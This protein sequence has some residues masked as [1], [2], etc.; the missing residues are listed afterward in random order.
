MALSNN[1]FLLL[2]NVTVWLTLV[3]PAKVMAASVVPG[4]SIEAKPFPNVQPVSTNQI[5][6]FSWGSFV[7][8][9]VV[10]LALLL[11]FAVAVKRFSRSTSGSSSWFKLLD[12]QQMGPGHNLY[13]VELAGRMQILGVTNQ[14]MVKIADLDDAELAGEILQD[15]AW[16]NEQILP[17]WWSQLL[18][19][20]KGSKFADELKRFDKGGD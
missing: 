2:I 19:N 8:I 5:N 11:F 20:I 9:V 14:T 6:T 16:R 15:L 18:A 12:R 1:R 3:Y 7:V 17:P 4:S 10:F 13:L